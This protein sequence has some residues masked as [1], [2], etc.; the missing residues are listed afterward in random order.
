M[1]GVVYVLFGRRCNHLSCLHQYFPLV[2][3][4][5]YHVITNADWF[6]VPVRSAV[7]S[8]LTTWC[9]QDYSTLYIAKTEFY[10][11]NVD[12]LAVNAILADMT[13]VLDVCWLDLL[14]TTCLHESDEVLL[15]GLY[16]PE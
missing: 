2:F 15:V 6:P 9:D 14:S 5:H 7:K 8:Y 1:T 12:L 3:K 16:R 4:K 10:G 13:G 11:L